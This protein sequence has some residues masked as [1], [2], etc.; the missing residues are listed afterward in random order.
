MKS[1]SG[2]D[3]GAD[4]GA[5]AVDSGEKYF[6]EWLGVWGEGRRERWVGV[7]VVVER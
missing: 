3:A 5:D 6:Q 4:T 7:G 1:G 2:S